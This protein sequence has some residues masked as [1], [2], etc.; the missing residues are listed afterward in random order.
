VVRGEN[1]TSSHIHIGSG[2][3]VYIAGQAPPLCR[4]VTEAIAGWTN[5]SHINDRP[6]KGKV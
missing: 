3:L 4:T 2:I 1:A 6:R 5:A